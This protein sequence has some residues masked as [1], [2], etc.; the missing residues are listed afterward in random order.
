MRVI[1]TAGHVD[2][3][4]STLIEALT[5]VHPDRLKEE[6]AREMT[7]DLGFGWLQLP[8][9]QEIGIVDVPGHRDFI[10][11]MLAGIG[12]IDAVLLVVAA[13]EG[14]M[15]QTRE[16]LAIINLLRI[17]AGIIVITK[18]DLI[19]DPDWLAAIEADVRVAVKDTV[20][21]DAPIVRV[22]ARTQRGLDSLVMTLSAVLS[23]QIVRPDLGRPRL[24]VDRVFTISGFGTIVTG[25]LLDGQLALGDEVEFLPSGLQG[26]VRGLQTHHKHIE[27]AVPGSRTAVNVSGIAADDLRRGEVLGHP[28]QWEVTRRIDAH[29][30][31]LP[32]AARGLAHG[33]STK[34]FLGTSE[35]IARLRVLNTDELTPG[36]AAWIQLEMQHPIV[37][38]RGDAF[39]LRRPSPAETLGG[40]V[41]A[42]PHPRGRHRRFD[43]EVISAL[44]AVADG[45]PVDILLEAALALNA[46]TYRDIVRRSHITRN[47]AEAALHELIASGKLIP[48]EVGPVVVEGDLLAMPAPHWSNLQRQVLTLV[49]EYHH[50]YPLRGGLPRG[51]LKSQLGISA[52]LL[53]ASIDKLVA[54]GVLSVAGSVVGRAGHEAHFNPAQQA[55][56]DLLLGRFDASRYSP[57]SIKDC[58]EAVG[59]EV[60]SALIA[61][62][63]LRPVSDEI[64]FRKGDYDSMV[65]DL[66][67]AL[68]EKG[69]ITLGEVRDM[70]HTSRRYAQA[71]LEHLDATGV[72]R[73]SG[74]LRIAGT[75]F[76][77]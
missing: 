30:S 63:A 31:L 40:G 62:G 11:N 21:Q 50:R 46:A 39:I 16:H 24:P 5:G 2:H 41:I 60:V 66:R 28:G 14:V 7:I 27:R 32:S 25:T 36:Q 8:D 67:A 47:A 65:V 55:A 74:D 3:G 49:D 48:L 56:V 52:R 73:R 17:P 54:D 4:K 6:Q 69:Q 58:R 51:E 18:I 75:R 1:G 15:P 42:D 44:A 53:N 26:R 33:A 29:F 70:F 72:T 57:P 20:L 13:D 43:T 12:G 19:T 34:L 23:Q 68:R 45:N 38:V 59:D 37:C 64:A 35:T 71:L 77:D 76:R 22:S 61:Q 10:E 9:G